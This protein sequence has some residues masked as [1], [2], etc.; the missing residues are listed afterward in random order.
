MLQDI[1]PHKLYNQYQADKVCQP[2][3]VLICLKDKTLLVGGAE[4]ELQFP[5]RKELAGDFACQYLFSLDEQ[6]YYLVF[7]EEEI[8]AEGYRYETLRDI[9]YQYKG[10]RHL[11]YAAYTAY[12]LA[13][14]Y[15]DNCF[16]GRCGHETQHSEVERA[17]VCPACGNV[18]YPR[19]IPAVIVGVIDGDR[20]L[21]T[22]YANRK[23]S[24]YA[25][26]AGFTEIGETLEECVAREV[27]EEVGLKVKNIRYYKSQPW[28]SAL[29]ILTG[30][31][32]EV[33]GDTTIRLEEEELKEGVWV[34][35]EDIE[36]QADDFSLTH[37][38]MMAF[39]EGKI[40]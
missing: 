20:I 2:D 5:K 15:R 21:M 22:K 19:L 11:M 10:P 23:M 32:C 24:F 38:M 30:F 16:C 14:W 26:V 40:R 27:M 1:R 36:G 6:D 35:R 7:A 37:A 4:H 3:D 12:H 34:K 31:F 17:M 39:K 28:G 13:M 29:D 18:I 9:R 25:L 8:V 33:D